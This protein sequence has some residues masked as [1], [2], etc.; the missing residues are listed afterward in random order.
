MIRQCPA[1]DS[2]G[3]A[4]AI[5]FIRSSLLPCIQPRCKIVLLSSVLCECITVHSP[6]RPTLT[7]LEDLMHDI[8]IRA[9]QNLMNS[10][11]LALVLSP[12]LLRGVNPLVDVQLCTITPRKSTLASVLQVCIEK[13]F[14]VFKD[15]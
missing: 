9:D 1:A 5:N 4:D 2:G 11:N 6:G 13:Y 10:H 8:A 14:E 3:G 12:N 7:F 15:I